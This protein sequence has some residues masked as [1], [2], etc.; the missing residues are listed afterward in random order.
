MYYAVLSEDGDRA[1]TGDDDGKLRLWTIST[2]KDYYRM[3]EDS[4]LIGEH[5][6]GIQSIG[7]STNGECVG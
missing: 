4:L 7:L 5:Q 6:G 1:I 2:S 3:D